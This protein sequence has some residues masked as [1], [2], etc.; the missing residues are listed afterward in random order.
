MEKRIQINQISSAFFGSEK[1]NS[2]I[3]PKDKIF[4]L[5]ENRDRIFWERVK[6][7]KDKMQKITNISS[8]LDKLSLS[9][10]KA[11]KSGI[12]IAKDGIIRSA[13]QILSQKGVNISKLRVDN[14]SS[15]LIAFLKNLFA[16]D[17]FSVKA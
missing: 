5:I 6:I 7:F 1:K 8:K 12:K 16:F 3:K 4:Q 10:S 2:N 11:A 15:S 17:L 9:P 13:N 14:F